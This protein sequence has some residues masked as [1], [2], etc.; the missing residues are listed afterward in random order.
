MVSMKC[1]CYM[2]NVQ[3]LL[4]D[5]I[6]PYERRCGE[7]FNGPIIPFGAMVAYHPMSAKNLSRLHQ[8]GKKVLPGIFIGYALQAGQM[9]KRR[10]FR[11]RH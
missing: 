1:Y 8:S 5:G 7:P 6:T 9:W 3:D 2:R 10:C 4:S 11:R